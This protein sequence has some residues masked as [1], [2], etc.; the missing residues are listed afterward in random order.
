MVFGRGS[1]AIASTIHIRKMTFREYNIKKIKT[2]YLESVMSNVFFVELFIMKGF[3]DALLESLWYSIV[4]QY[5]SDI[6]C[7][8]SCF[9][10]EN[11]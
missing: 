6:D 2:R 4:C 7:I 5:S 1:I 8:S 3:K 10:P 11:K 9:H